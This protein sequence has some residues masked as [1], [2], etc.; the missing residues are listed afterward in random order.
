MHE[1]VKGKGA[2]GYR[3]SEAWHMGAVE[4]KRTDP[5]EEENIQWT[6]P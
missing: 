5:P 1:T 2:G 4:G 3:L 6:P